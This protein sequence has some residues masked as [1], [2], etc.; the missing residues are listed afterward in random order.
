MSRVQPIK[1]SLHLGAFLLPKGAGLVYKNFIVI[2]GMDGA[3]KSTLAKSLGEDFKNS[4]VTHEPMEECH[5]LEE[6]LKD[7][8]KHWKE[9]IEPA[10]KEGQTVICDRFMD[11]TLVYQTAMGQSLSSSQWDAIFKSYKKYGH[12]AVL[13]IALVC[14]P[15]TAT[16]RIKSRGEINPAYENKEALQRQFNAFS[17]L[18]LASPLHTLVDTTSIAPLMVRAAA[19][20]AVLKAQSSIPENYFRKVGLTSRDFE[21]GEIK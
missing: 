13:T 11:S 18:A 14:D 21:R 16:E 10:L 8:D 6:F 7:R 9:V 5:S 17:A 4:L 3:G 2:E 19:T 12:E 20:M 1:I 15:D